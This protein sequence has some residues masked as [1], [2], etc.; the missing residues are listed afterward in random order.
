MALSVFFR[1]QSRCATAVRKVCPRR[2]NPATRI[3][4]NQIFLNQ[5]NKTMRKIFLFTAAMLAI[6]GCSEDNTH[7]K[8]SPVDEPSADAVTILATID[9]IPS[10]TGD[11]EAYAPLWQEGDQIVVGYKVG[12]TVAIVDGP[13]SGFNG[14]VEELDVEKNKVRVT[15]S[16]FGREM[17]VE[18]ELD[19][20][21]LVSE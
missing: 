17:P 16:M 4:T 18:L 12:D 14:V 13:L 11:G 15:V 3:S 10:A 6:A 20:A 21:E 5:Q 7:P 19:Q 8:V 2:A 1:R 9:A